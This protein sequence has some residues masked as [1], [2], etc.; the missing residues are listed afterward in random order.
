MI[1]QVLTL[2]LWA[3]REDAT[4]KESTPNHFLLAIMFYYGFNRSQGLNM[5]EHAKH[6]AACIDHYEPAKCWAQD[7]SPQLKNQSLWKRVECPDGR[8][9]SKHPIHEFLHQQLELASSAY[10]AD[11][12]DPNLKILFASLHYCLAVLHKY[13][14]GVEE[15]INTSVKHL[16]IGAEHG[17]I[18]ASYLLG[19]VYYFGLL[20]DPNKQNIDL[21]DY[22]PRTESKYL[23]TSYRYV[24]LAHDMVRCNYVRANQNFFLARKFMKHAA[25]RGIKQARNIIAR[26][27]VNGEAVPQCARVAREWYSNAKELGI[28]GYNKML[29][30]GRFIKQDY[31]GVINEKAKV[32]QALT[33]LQSISLGIK[34]QTE[35]SK[36]L[37]EGISLDLPKILDLF[38]ETYLPTIPYRSIVTDPSIVIEGN[39]GRIQKAMIGEKI[40]ALKTLKPE[41]ITAAML[42]SFQKEIE[43]SMSLDHKNIVKYYGSTIIGHIKL[44]ILTGILMDWVPNS[45]SSLLK[46][47]TY[48][49]RIQLEYALYVDGGGAVPSIIKTLKGVAQGMEYLHLNG[50]LHRDLRPKNILVE[51]DDTAK[52]CDMGIS[53]VANTSAAT[54]VYSFANK[55]I[56]QST[57]I[58]NR[59]ELD[60]WTY[61]ELINRVLNTLNV[62]D[63]KLTQLA[64]DI[65]DQR[66]NITFTDIISR[67]DQMYYNV[68]NGASVTALAAQLGNT[69]VNPVVEA[70]L[71][72]EQS[73]RAKMKAK[74]SYHLGMLHLRQNKVIDAFN[75]FNE[76]AN[77]YFPAAVALSFCHSSGN[78]TNVNAELAFK[79]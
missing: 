18:H 23:D 3:N 45:W 28:F 75:Y 9:V 77:F 1:D 4:I 47:E 56:E 54:S 29:F 8:L 48:R 33:L 27:Y 64:S 14:W 24:G 35:G 60:V 50:I 76:C 10:D 65:I 32:S 79:W 40:Y 12:N 55:Q 2:R 74:S 53:M 61:G 22:L 59:K 21:G 19:M 70:E 58:Q 30:Q 72:I 63:S 34:G 69:N 26:M 39:F 68:D 13:R 16:F 51:Q 5:E 42:P 62:A 15:D 37:L 17:E 11:N 49:V 7:Q 57:L 25:D 66:D 78:G 44:G 43:I 73:I 38:R 46:E 52:L 41:K 6:L 71:M 36:Q 31:D 20:P 67:I